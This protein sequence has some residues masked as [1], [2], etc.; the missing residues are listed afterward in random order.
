MAIAVLK[1]HDASSVMVVSLSVVSPSVSCVSSIDVTIQNVM[2]SRNFA[3]AEA[4]QCNFWPVL[5]SY[6]SCAVE[7]SVNGWWNNQMSIRIK[8]NR[9]H[10]PFVNFSVILGFEAIVLV[11]L[12]TSNFRTIFGACNDACEANCNEVLLVLGPVWIQSRPVRHKFAFNSKFSDQ[13]GI[14]LSGRNA[15]S[16]ASCTV[17]RIASW[18][19][20]E[21][22]ATDGTRA[23]RFLLGEANRAS[24]CCCLNWPRFASKCC[25]CDWSSFIAL[26]LY[27]ATIFGDCS[28]CSCGYA[29]PGNG[30]SGCSPCNCSCDSAT[31]WC[32]Q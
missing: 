2:I 8:A 9:F 4:T 26:V 20:F 5:A 15:D 16:T 21:K 12:S 32:L 31:L 28:C 24:V 25:C 11:M 10:W 18:K 19:P 7:P 22:P 30:G 6:W 3:N 17:S 13:V 27:S 29:Y 1:L 14:P 23:L